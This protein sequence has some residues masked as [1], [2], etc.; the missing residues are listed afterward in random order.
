MAPPPQPEPR[1]VGIRQRPPFLSH[2]WR[3]PPSLRSVQA[4]ARPLALSPG[5]CATRTS[6]SPLLSRPK[7]GEPEREAGTMFRRKLTALDY[8][9]PAGFNCKGEVAARQLR[10]TDSAHGRSQRPHP[11]FLPRP[12]AA[13][14]PRGPR[15]VS[16]LPSREH[17]CSPP[18]LSF[19]PDTLGL[20]SPL[21]PRLPQ[22][23]HLVH[24]LTPSIRPP[25][26]A[27]T[28]EEKYSLSTLVLHLHGVPSN[29]AIP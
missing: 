1:L 22:H 3:R 2:D 6:S 10:A 20:R 5:A 17:L 14:S 16:S 21:Q 19:G 12:T 28:L 8:H 29:W 13:L 15:P 18:S 7:P 11:G 27:S 24:L 9:N 23:R 26:P 25:P 4:P